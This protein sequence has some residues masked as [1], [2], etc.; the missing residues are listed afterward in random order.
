MNRRPAAAFVKRTVRAVSRRGG[1]SALFGRAPAVSTNHFASSFGPETGL[2]LRIRALRTMTS[3]TTSAITTNP[4]RT[5]TITVQ[6]RAMAAIPMIPY[7]FFNVRG[8]A[9]AMA[10]ASLR[11]RVAGSFRPIRKIQ[12]RHTAEAARGSEVLFIHRF[13][14]DSAVHRFAAGASPKL[15]GVNESGGHCRFILKARQS[16]VRRAVWV[17]C[18]VTAQRSDS[19]TSSFP[20][21]ENRR[22]A[23]SHQ[24]EL[25]R[26]GDAGSDWTTGRHSSRRREAARKSRVHHPRR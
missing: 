11:T 25:L 16:R 3:T 14:N 7:R 2:L 8:T 18:V 22:G 5:P 26:L 10:R 9:P 17:D 20:A 15:D 21:A 12:R 4:P 24:Q 13:S 23:F 1:L 19:G 6:R